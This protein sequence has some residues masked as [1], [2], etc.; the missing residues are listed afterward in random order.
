[1]ITFLRLFAGFVIS[2]VGI[3]ITNLVHISQKPLKVCFNAFICIIV[4]AIL[5]YISKNS[6]G[7]KNQFKLN[8]PKLK[9]II[10]SIVYN[11]VYVVLWFLVILLFKILYK[12]TIIKFSLYGVS[13][14]ILFG[15]LIAAFM[16]E[17]LFRYYII[18]ILQKINFNIYGTILIGSL[19]FSLIHLNQYSVIAIALIVL[20]GIAFSVTFILTRSILTVT[21]LHAIFNVLSV[22]TLIQSNVR[23]EA[24]LL[25]CLISISLYLLFTIF[26]W[27]RTGNV[28]RRLR[29]WYYSSSAQPPSSTTCL[30]IEEP[31]V[32]A[33][34]K[35]RAE[36]K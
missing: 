11:C 20:I 13:F 3:V 21:L 30:S 36:N 34:R 22:Y 31:P 33:G 14:S 23:F 7:N 6:Y 26:I 5:F 17:M 15:I 18:G 9:K 29:D 35:V 32:C 28:I 8:K 2:Y 25:I 19:L 12:D 27:Y 24:N 1:M 16:E 4:S 10:P